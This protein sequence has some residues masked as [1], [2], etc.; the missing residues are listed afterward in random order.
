MIFSMGGEAVITA[1]TDAGTLKRMRLDTPPR[2]GRYHYVVEHAD[3]IDHLRQC[4]R[5]AGWRPTRVQAGVTTNGYDMVA[6]VQVADHG[7]DLRKGYGLFMGGV[8]AN[9]SERKSWLY[10][11]VVYDDQ[12]VPLTVV[13]PG[14]RHQA[15]DFLGWMKESVSQLALD[16]AEF[17]RVVTN[18]RAVEVT[19]EQESNVLLRAASE[20]LIRYSELAKFHHAKESQSDAMSAW[21]VV[22]RF[23]LS[24]ARGRGGPITFNPRLD[25]LTQVF[26]FRQ[27]LIEAIAS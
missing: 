16:A 21:G 17:P 18:M 10:A 11:G 22:Y 5:D 1:N 4:I 27:L 13:E 24:V 12:A 23:A 9:S 3:Y 26:R 8:N 20:R 14:K 19:E 2:V 7:I 15:I 25:Q 6:A